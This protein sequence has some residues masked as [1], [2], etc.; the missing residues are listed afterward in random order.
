VLNQIFESRKPEK[1]IPEIEGNYVV[2]SFN[3]DKVN[4]KTQLKNN[5]PSTITPCLL[6]P[7]N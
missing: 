3:I 4:G 6:Q 5:G 2:I 1:I 7:T